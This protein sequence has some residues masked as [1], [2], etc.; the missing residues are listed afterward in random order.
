[1]YLLWFRR[2]VSC[3]VLVVRVGLISPHC[4]FWS[5]FLALS[6]HFFNSRVADLAR[7]SSKSISLSITIDPPMG[8]VHISF[9]LS[10]PEAL[11]LPPSPA[12]LFAHDFP[13][14]SACALP[15]RPWL[16]RLV[17]SP[18][19]YSSQGCNR[20][21]ASA[22]VRQWPD[23]LGIIVLS[24][25]SSCHSPLLS[26]RLRIGCIFGPAGAVVG[27]GFSYSG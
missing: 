27:R 23:I 10:V 24:F 7:D 14:V 19:A 11:S 13:S 1:M 26:H 4:I 3:S 9:G 15:T 17:A 18:R 12:P 8:F 16:A 20:L 2:A 22:V 21:L 6:S 25:A 5:V